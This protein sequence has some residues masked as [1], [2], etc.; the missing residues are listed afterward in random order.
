L[1]A[2][3]RTSSTLRQ[4]MREREISNELYSMSTDES[5]LKVSR[6]RNENAIVALFVSPRVCRSIG[7]KRPNRDDSRGTCL[8]VRHLQ[9]CYDRCNGHMDQ[10]RKSQ[11][12]SDVDVGIVLS[13][14]LLGQKQLLL[15]RQVGND[16][17]QTREEL[18]SGLVPLALCA[19][20][21]LCE[22]RNTSDE[23]RE[24]EAH[25]LSLSNRM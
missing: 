9:R 11:L 23:E 10:G 20:T 6:T 25:V 12:L 21:S 19:R 18:G 7:D 4:T 17:C 14:T 13:A 24:R 3:P 8:A 5:E 2:S 1:M 22:P 15:C 16:R